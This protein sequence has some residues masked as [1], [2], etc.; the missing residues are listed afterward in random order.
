[1]DYDVASLPRQ[2]FY[3][4]ATAAIQPRPIAWI[5]S[6]SA[7]G[8]ANLAPFSFFTVASLAPPVLSVTLTNRRDGGPKDTLRN[9]RE[10]GECVIN[11]VTEGTV[12]AMNASCGDYPPEVSEI[13]VLG[14]ATVPSR[15]VAPPGIA[16]APVRFECRLRQT[17]PFGAGP[18]GT[19]VLFLD[20]VHI[21]ADDDVLADGWVSPAAIASVGKLGGDGYA[22]TGER[23][24]LPRPLIQP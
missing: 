17:L 14:L 18:G 13:A 6:L 1:M 3:Q 19:H 21:Q 2:R 9:L 8:V 4:I 12:E 24:D 22:R 10:S 5:S 16:A 23:F 15:R 7:A 11:I 20:V